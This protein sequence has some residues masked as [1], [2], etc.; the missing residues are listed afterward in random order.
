MD[1]RLVGIIAAC[2][3]FVACDPDKRLPSKATVTAQGTLTWAV[4]PEVGELPFAEVE[5]SRR[6]Q[7]LDVRLRGTQLLR[8]SDYQARPYV[9]LGRLPAAGKSDASTPELGASVFL[10]NHDFEGKTYPM[11]QLIAQAAGGVHDVVSCL[12][13]TK[14]PRHELL[15]ENARVVPWLAPTPVP[16]AKFRVT[17]DCNEVVLPEP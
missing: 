3:V 14:G 10:P 6:G 13:E 15:C 5:C 8:G 17:F 7:A 16:K 11:M 4:G 1:G 2:V 12:V 9:L